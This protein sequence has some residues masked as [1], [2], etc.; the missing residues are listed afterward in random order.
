MKKIKKK[1]D[2]LKK[3]VILSTYLYLINDAENQ[4]ENKRLA[5]KGKI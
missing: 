2:I 3:G 5:D 4:N 1:I